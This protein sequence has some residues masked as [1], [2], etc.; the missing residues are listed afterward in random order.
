MSEG[1]KQPDARFAP[2]SRHSRGLGGLP[3]LTQR[4]PKTRRPS[5]PQR[6]RTENPDYTPSKTTHEWIRLERNKLETL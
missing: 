2:E 5:Q 6:Q 4:R 3:L 1:A